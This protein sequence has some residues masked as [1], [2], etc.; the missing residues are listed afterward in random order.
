MAIASRYLTVSDA[1][2][3]WGSVCLNGARELFP[4]DV[5]GSSSWHAP[6]IIRVQ[7]GNDIVET[8]IVGPKNIFRRRVWRCFY[9]ANR[10][11][12]GDRVLLEQLDPYL[13]RI[14]K[15]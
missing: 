12:R 11:Q 14:S 5:I 10:I 3:R 13:Y 15:A 2:L 6:R 7:W 4:Q 1:N 8:D 9:D